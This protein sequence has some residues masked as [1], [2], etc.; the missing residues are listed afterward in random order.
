MPRH[1]NQNKPYKSI[2]QNF[3]PNSAQHCLREKGGKT[4]QTVYINKY[5]SH[6]LVL[7]YSVLLLRNY[8]FALLQITS[9]PGYNQYYVEKNSSIKKTMFLIWHGLNMQADRQATPHCCAR[10]HCCAQ[11]H[12]SARLWSKHLKLTKSLQV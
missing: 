8:I 7:I 3:M 6:S 1:N 5:K 10:P 11:P 12:G 2:I 9:L 4:F